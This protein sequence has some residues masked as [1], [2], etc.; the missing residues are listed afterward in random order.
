MLKPAP[1]HTRSASP[2][3]RALYLGARDK[4]QVSCTGEALVVRNDRAQTLR[5][6]LSRVARVVS[7][8]AVDWSGEALAL[9][10]RHSIGISWVDA[11]GEALGTC[12]PRQRSHARMAMALDLW[13]ETPVGLDLYH[14]WLKS[15]RMA[16]LVHWGQQSTGPS[17]S[18][19][20]P[21]L[22]E[23]TKRE[24]VYRQ[25][26]REHLP[27]GLRS[28]CLAY[29]AAQLGSHGVG[30]QMWGPDAEPIDLENDLC[31][32]LW[33]EMNLCTGTLA[34]AAQ[35]DKDLIALSERWTARNGAALSLHLGSLYRTALKA[36]YP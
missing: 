20:S 29:T 34:D 4:K 22:W 12:Y 16:V 30:P 2:G 33:A 9:C 17:D 10:M 21:V 7:S 1:T 25:Y 6:P 24:W 18:T 27:R 8:T 5:Y 19:V 14:I 32:L 13:L 23:N 31:E 35:G 3:A 11:R 26:F 36:I 15:R 28:Y